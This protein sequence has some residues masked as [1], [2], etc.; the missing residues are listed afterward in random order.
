LN[1]SINLSTLDELVN[2]FEVTCIC[3]VLYNKSFQSSFTVMNNA[4][5]L[6]VQQ[7]F[8]KKKIIIQLKSV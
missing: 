3:I 8:K 6:A 5:W 2:E 4:F 1:L 7:L